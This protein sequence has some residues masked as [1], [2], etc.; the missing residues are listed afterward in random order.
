MKPKH[1]PIRICVVSRDTKNGFAEGCDE[2][3]RNGWIMCG[4]PKVT[5]GYNN[6]PLFTQFFVW[7]VENK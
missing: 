3:L 6:H 5:N 4:E 7:Q 2:K 1:R